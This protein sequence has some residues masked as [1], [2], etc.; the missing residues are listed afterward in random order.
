VP[1]GWEPTA[2]VIGSRLASV[3]VLLSFISIS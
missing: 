2:S 3:R 1:T